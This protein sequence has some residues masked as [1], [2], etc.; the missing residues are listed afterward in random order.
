M[1]P[2]N[3]LTLTNVARRTELTWIRASPDTLEEQLMTPLLGQHPVE[4]GMHDTLPE[5]LALFRTD[6]VYANLFPLAFPR[7]ADPFTADSLARAIASF[8]RTLISDTS[9]YDD[10]LRGD[11]D[12]MSDAQVRGMDLFFSDR[13]GCWRCHSG[14]DFDEPAGVNEERHGFFNVGLYNIDGQG[15]YP[16]GGGGLFEETGAP[17]DMGRFRTPTLRNVTLTKPYYHDGT[18]PSLHVVLRDFAR[19]GRNVASGATPGDGR[20]S[21]VK[22]PWIVGFSAT[23]AELADLEAFMGALTDLK[24]INDPRFADPWPRDED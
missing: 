13:I 20:L 11:A 6:P 21:P 12:A 4:L 24:F 9:P 5:V 3:T 1:H 16:A 7:V 2:R 18:G 15:A 19:G 23:D 22:S 10:F 17:E 14:P 8:E